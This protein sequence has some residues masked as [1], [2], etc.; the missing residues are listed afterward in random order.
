M[1][2]DGT[3][4]R[5]L[6]ATSKAVVPKWLI[7]NTYKILKQVFDQTGAEEQYATSNTGETP[8]EEL[9]KHLQLQ[10]LDDAM[11]DAET[12]IAEGNGG[13]DAE[14]EN[15]LKAC[16]IDMDAEYP[17]NTFQFSVDDVPVITQGDLH[18][19][20][21]KQKGGKTSLVAILIAA[22]LR[23][24]W[25]RV[26]CLEKGI[27]VLYIDTEMKKI[28]TQ[29]LGAKTAKMAGV[30][31]KALSDRIHLVNFRPLT[32]KEMET[33]ILYFIHK[34][35]PQL[36]IIDGIVDL[37]ANFND[38]E[39]SQNLVL[40]FL[41]KIAEMEKCAIINV[42]HTNKTDG[43]TELRGHLGAYFEQKGVTV[44]KCE[45]DDDS[46]IVTVKFPT[47]RYA[48]VPEFHFTFDE[49]GIPV[50]A[51][52]LHQK[53][54]Q[55]KA[56]SKQEQKEAERKAVYEERKQIVIDILNAN[57]SSMDRKDLIEAVMQRIGKKESTVKTLIKNM[58]GESQPSISE[59]D[60]VI[61]ALVY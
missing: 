31:V 12:K 4:K 49:N 36:V 34:Y 61:T 39:A 44:M 58:K 14:L 51:D 19:I 8:Q 60:S 11:A 43:Y 6:D 25:N 55:Q 7:I 32:P 45:K 35:N 41:M 38:V 53:L 40:N 26:K 46:N 24:N 18:T 9:Q 17:K 54:E 42:L 23:G 47:H 50:S 48:P 56:Q 10:S 15:K 37:C 16:E 2:N 30:D 27:G 29:S 28:D 20:G 22:V 3:I 52:E 59:V 33:G 57:G 5:Q 1:G 21:A 13:I